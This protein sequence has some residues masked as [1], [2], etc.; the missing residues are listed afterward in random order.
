MVRNRVSAW[1]KYQKYSGFT[2]KRG[3]QTREAKRGIKEEV[4]TFKRIVEITMKQNAHGIDG[5]REK[6]HIQFTIS[7]KGRKT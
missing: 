3:R 1:G 6:S 7:D 4:R 5:S 2:L